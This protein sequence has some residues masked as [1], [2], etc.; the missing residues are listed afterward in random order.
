[1]KEGGTENILDTE[2]GPDGAWRLL[3]AEASS[4]AEKMTEG[5]DGFENLQPDEQVESLKILMSELTEDNHNR[6][7]IEVLAKRATAIKAT[8]EYRK[9]MEG[10]GINPGSI[11]NETA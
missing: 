6:F 5:I 4:Q 8:E 10:L 11:I 7:I 3:E 9:I 1:M 2:K